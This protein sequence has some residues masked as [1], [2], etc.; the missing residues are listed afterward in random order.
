MQRLDA[1]YDAFVIAASPQLL[2]LAYRLTGDRHLAE[3]LL[4]SSLLKVARQWPRAREHPTA[5]A[6]RTIV[7]LATDGWRR[8]RARPPEIGMAAVPDRQHPSEQTAYD[9]REVLFAAL[10][11]LKPRQRAVLVL[12]FWEDRS[13]D[14]TAELLNT[15][16]GNIKSTTHRGLERLRTILAATEGAQP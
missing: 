1:T 10:R 15:S 3:D 13:I 14:D 7:N 16:T 2:R 5:Y 4:Q 12:R 6:Q 9:E 8:R 11:Q